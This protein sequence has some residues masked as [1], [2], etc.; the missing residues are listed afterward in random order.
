M[1]TKY[2]EIVSII[3][4]THSLEI[5]HDLL[6]H[7]H[8]R[9]IAEVFTYLE[10]EE[11]NKL[12]QCFSKQEL[13]DIFSYI[14]DASEYLIGLDKEETAELIEL[15]DSDDALKI[16]EDFEEEERLE[17]I[18]LID[19]EIKE[20]IE[21]ITSYDDDMIGHYMTNNYISINVNS[22]IKS[23][24]KT[25]IKEASNNDNFTIIYVVRDDESLYGTI[26][27]KDLIIAR[28]E[29]RLEDIIKKNFPSILDATSVGEAL[30]ELKEYNIDS[31]PVVNEK[32]ILLGVITTSD[33]LEAFEDELS[34]DYARLAGLSSAEEFEQSTL[35]SVKKRIPWLCI[36]LILGLV[37]SLVVGIFENTIVAVPVIVFFQ[38]MILGMGGNV[39]TQSLAVTI[40]TISDEEISRKDLVKHI[41]KEIKVAA[42]N[43]LLI[44]LLSYVV[45][46]IYL[47]LSKTVI[48]V[49]NGIYIP[50][51]LLTSFVISISL[52]LTMIVSGII[53]T[54]T[55]ILL[56]KCKIDPAVASG[57]FITSVNDI[58]AILIYYG[59]ALL[60]FKILL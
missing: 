46:F 59:I 10:E 31:V 52:L 34:D 23:A 26:E 13:A 47:Y 11:L 45:V 5:L 38:S 8:E 56:K 22:T 27:L 30:I 37:I 14:E 60:V 12:Y 36:L 58:T 42:I 33:I 43:G 20:D 40:R 9:D 17:I 54:I 50:D 19:E 4:N 32:N 21:L 39:G 2:N 24:M 28:S 1:E 16:L 7:Y 53:G 35:L 6:S 18:D 49:D 48:N 3:K 55:P 41:F 25:V 15:M 29:E 51:L 44:S 57:P